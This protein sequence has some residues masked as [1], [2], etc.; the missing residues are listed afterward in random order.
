LTRGQQKSVIETLHFINCTATPPR[1]FMS[2]LVHVR[3][4]LLV[5][6]LCYNFVVVMAT[7]S[8]KRSNSG[9]IQIFGRGFTGI[10]QV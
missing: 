1:Q 6:P 5:T 4:L 8:V 7:G 9:R 10:D 3:L 2:V